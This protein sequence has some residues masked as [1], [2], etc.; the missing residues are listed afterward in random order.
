MEMDFYAL[1]QMDDCIV[2]HTTKKYYTKLTLPR[3]D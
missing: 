1:Y 3:S 2:V